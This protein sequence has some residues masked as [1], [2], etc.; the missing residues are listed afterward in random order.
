MNRLMNDDVKI[1]V[2]R[3]DVDNLPVDLCDDLLSWQTSRIQQDSRPAGPTVFRREEDYFAL[4]HDHSATDAMVDSA[5]TS[6]TPSTHSEDDDGDSG[7]GDP[8]DSERSMPRHMGHQNCNAHQVVAALPCGAGSRILRLPGVL[9]RVGLARSTVY[10]AIAE[11]SFPKSVSLGPRAVGWLE[12]EIDNWLEGRIASRRA[13]TSKDHVDTSACQATNR[14]ARARTSEHSP[15]TQPLKPDPKQSPRKVSAL[16]G[17][18][19]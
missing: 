15:G 13:P 5:R 1:V 2:K 3:S 14:L 11:N 17:G 8:P 18:P 19:R 12:S 16:A 7:D 6:T 9:N 10:Q 4:W